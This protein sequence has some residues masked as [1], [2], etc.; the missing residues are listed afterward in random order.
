MFILVVFKVNVVTLG[1]VVP[2]FAACYV[3]TTRTTRIPK[4]VSG[5]RSNPSWISSQQQLTCSTG[6]SFQ[7]SWNWQGEEKKHFWTLVSSF[8]IAALAEELSSWA[9]GKMLLELGRRESSVS[10]PPCSGESQVSRISVT[11]VI[12]FKSKFSGWVEPHLYLWLGKL[13]AALLSK[14]SLYF[15]QT[16]AK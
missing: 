9:N 16:L 4:N 14:F 2:F 8:L 7:L 13:K 15:Y 5:M 6:T 3:I 1:W 11:L 10:P 12:I